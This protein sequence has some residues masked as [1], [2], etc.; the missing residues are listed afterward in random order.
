MSSWVR[1]W[2]DMPTDPKWR[3]VA[4]K[5]GQPL[6][7]VIAVFTMMLTNAGGNADERGCLMGWD[8]EDAAAALDIDALT[9]AAIR[10]AMQGKVLE[11]ERL[12]GWERRQ[13]KRE[14]AGVG[15][16]VARHRETKA[17][18]V[19]RDVTQCNAPDA[20]ADAEVDAEK[21]DITANAASNYAFDGR[22]IRLTADDLA[23]WQKSYPTIPDIVA[24]LQSRDD[25]LA[26][27]ADDATKKKWFISTSNWLASQQA[28]ARVDP[29][30]G[31]R[32][33]GHPNW[34]PGD[35]GHSGI[36]T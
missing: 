6:P 5:S 26:T 9:V 33:K 15:L 17:N 14:D 22:V 31:A 16:R 8:D 25:W 2:H 12:T 1:L 4:R 19:K 3:V 23:T 30:P 32:T 24:L 36:P 28:K 21:K 10:D 34:G 20:D 11:G 13:P 35:P 7:C 29:P 27:E 18:A